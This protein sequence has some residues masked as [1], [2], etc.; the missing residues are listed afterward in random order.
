MRRSDIQTS[1]DQFDR[2]LERR[3][4][5]HSIRTCGSRSQDSEDSD[6][7]YSDSD[8]D[9]GSSN[10]RKRDYIDDLDDLP[11]RYQPKQ[12]RGAAVDDEPSVLQCHLT[13]FQRAILTILLTTVMCLSTV[14]IQTEN[15][16]MSASLSGSIAADRARTTN[17]YVKEYE[18]V[19]FST[20][21]QIMTSQ[22]LTNL[23]LSKSLQFLA[24][25]STPFNPTTDVP[26]FF[27]MPRSGGST[28]KDIMGMCLGLVEATDVG[29]RSPKHVKKVKEDV[30][31]RVVHSDDGAS[32]VNVDT[33]TA[34]GIHRAK[35][36]GL[37][38]SQ[39]ADVIVS[40]HLHPVATLFNADQPGRMFAMMRHPIERAVS[41][42]HYLGVA[43]WEP[44]YDPSLAYVSIEMYARSQRAEHNW[45]VRFLSN[46]L[47]RNVN[48]RHL[49]MAKEVL[50]QKCLIGLLD[51]KAESFMRFSQYFG[52]HPKTKDQTD[53]RD[54][55]LNWGWSNKHA[56]P[57]V[58]EGSI[59]WELLY[60]KN[61]LD[62]EL[63]EYAKELFQEQ[64]AMFQ[65]KKDDNKA[66]DDKADENINRLPHP[67]HDETD[68]SIKL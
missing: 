67:V 33:S 36:M 25:I 9:D 30:V 3:E 35:R 40:Q 44:T 42:F 13:R 53:C 41:M 62:M 50:R 32:F 38:E 6:S 12:R 60:K 45:A 57:E 5:G 66:G 17:S 26:L 51:D 48:E 15:R 39:L 65:S 43:N 63:Y 46:E 18:S 1:L 47:V 29:A 31:L 27:H 49:Q 10:Y 28:V 4:E 68:P 55:L 21:A 16:A 64:A 19:G 22:S 8:T 34:K 7:Y 56:H 61:S 20:T 58:E 14:R 24:D 2:L 23:Q 59:V 37:V 54:R 52:W 11:G